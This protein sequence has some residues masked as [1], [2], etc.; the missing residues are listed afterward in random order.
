MENLRM[1]LYAPIVAIGGLVGGWLSGEPNASEPATPMITAANEYRCVGN[2]EAPKSGLDVVAAIAPQSETLR[3]SLQAQNLDPTEIRAVHEVAIVDPFGR[4]ANT[5]ELSPT[6]VVGMGQGHTQNFDLPV[7]KVD[8]YYT[9]VIRTATG[10][11]QETTGL[12]DQRV[13]MKVVKGVATVV[14]R[15]EYETNSGETEAQT[16]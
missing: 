13:W 5:G 14:E 1:V 10:N 16:I 12:Q 4:P 3:L 8:G 6:F 9:V 15:D 2:N 11:G 7:P